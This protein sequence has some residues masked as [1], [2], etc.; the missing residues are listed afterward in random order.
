VPQPVGTDK[1]I[2]PSWAHVISADPPQ[3]RPGGI[4]R[5]PGSRRRGRGS[6]PA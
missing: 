3:G 1:M 5:G 4:H 2:Q 6:R